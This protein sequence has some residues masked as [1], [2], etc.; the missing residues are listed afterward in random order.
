MKTPTLPKG[1]TIADPKAYQVGQAACDA[2]VA[3]LGEVPFNEAQG[4]AAGFMAR[5]LTYIQAAAGDEYAR[6]AC[7]SLILA[8]Q[9]PV[10]ISGPAN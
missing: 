6:H 1:L 5:Y 9:N 3:E 10:I 2:A 8:L 7:K 4:M